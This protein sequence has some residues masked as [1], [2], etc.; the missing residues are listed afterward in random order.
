[1]YSEEYYR[2]FEGY[3]AQRHQDGDM[4]PADPEQF[5]S[6]FIT[7]RPECHFLEL[8][9]GQQLVAVA[10]VDLLLDGLSAIYTFFEP[11]LSK[12]SLGTLAVLLQIQTAARLEAPYVYLG[13]WISECRKMAYKS[14]YQPLEIYQQGKWHL[15]QEL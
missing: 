1:V 5:E 14:E 7:S 12:R 13:Y 11:A 8:R 3:I 4:Y 10:A 2:L 15:L 6:M 9:L